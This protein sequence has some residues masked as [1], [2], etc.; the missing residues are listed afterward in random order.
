MLVSV[1]PCNRIY[2]CHII[3]HRNVRSVNTKIVFCQMLMTLGQLFTSMTKSWHLKL[4]LNIKPYNPP[5]LPLPHCSWKTHANTNTRWYAKI[6]PSSVINPC[7][8]YE[9]FRFL[10]GSTVVNRLA[11]NLLLKNSNGELNIE[12]KKYNL[13][14]CIL[15]V[16][17]SF[18]F[19]CKNNCSTLYNHF[20]FCPR[21]LYIVWIWDCICTLAVSSTWCC[22]RAFRGLF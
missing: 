5:D 19:A 15:R 8:I 1:S 21:W 4:P 20:L 6:F 3:L 11:L 18:R 2:I 7:L 22:Q 17:F 9:N 10:G 16:C 12:E 14:T 13:K